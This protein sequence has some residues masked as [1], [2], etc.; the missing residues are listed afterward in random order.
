MKYLCFIAGFL[1]LL[2]FSSCLVAPQTPN[3]NPDDNPALLDWLIPKNAIIDRGAGNDSI[4]PILEPS[5]MSPGQ[6]HLK[7]NDL[8]IGVNVEGEF[9]VYPHNILNYHEVVNDV[10]KNKRVTITYSPY[11]GSAMAWETT[12]LNGLITTF[13]ISRLI[14]NSNHILHDKDSKSYW[15][16]MYSQCVAGSMKAFHVDNFGVVET[17]WSNWKFMFPSARVLSTATGYKFNY[18]ADPYSQYASSDTIEFLTQPID[19][20]LPVKERVHTLV[21]GTHAK[22]YRFSSFADSVSVIQ[23]NFQGLSVV[24]AGS[25]SRNFIVSYQRRVPNGPELDFSVNTDANNFIMVDSEGT[26]WD[27]FGVA[28]DGPR[29]GQRLNPTQS[30]MAY[31][32]AVGAMYPDALIY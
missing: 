32:F 27:I 18:N 26:K 4:P 13:S 22:V 14:Y 3:Q 21:V 8:V 5:F 7:D 20:R 9:R 2:Q 28:V 23:D 25:K 29:I 11:S 1:V 24:L 15:Q 17:T 10:I 16:Q 6:V 30:M 19:P 12:N 31:W